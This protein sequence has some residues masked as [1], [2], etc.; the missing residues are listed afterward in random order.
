LGILNRGEDSYID[1]LEKRIRVP[2][3]RIEREQKAT[4]SGGAALSVHTIMDREHRKGLFLFF[5]AIF[6]KK[7]RGAGKLFPF[8]MLFSSALEED[9]ETDPAK[10]RSL[11]FREGARKRRPNVALEE[12]AVERKFLREGAAAIFRTWERGDSKESPLFRNI[13][14]ALLSEKRVALLYT[15]KEEEDYHYSSAGKKIGLPFPFKKSD[16][17]ERPGPPFLQLLPERSA[18]QRRETPLY[19]GRLLIRVNG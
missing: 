3:Q 5:L 10:R 2:S 13:S 16:L 7:R 1:D 17:R 8:R 12:D 14:S 11:Q 6:K 4:T 19:R 18:S 15:R 9:V